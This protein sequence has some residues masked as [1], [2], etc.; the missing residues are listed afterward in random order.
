MQKK[1]DP[2]GWYANQAQGINIRQAE[3]QYGLIFAWL[4]DM[5]ESYQHLDVIWDYYQMGSPE[6]AASSKVNIVDKAMLYPGDPP[7][8]PILEV[9]TNAKGYEE[10]LLIYP[11]D[12]I[13]YTRDGELIS[14]GRMD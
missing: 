11:Y 3:Q 7:Q 13:A 1:Y 9:S 4:N 6:P 8:Y 10:L 12:F 14:I 2:T 5:D